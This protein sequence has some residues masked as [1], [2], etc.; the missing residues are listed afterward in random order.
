MEQSGRKRVQMT[1]NTRR[2]EPLS[3]LLSS[4]NNCP[5][6]PRIL[7][8]KEAVP[9]SSPGEGLNTCKSAVSEE[10]GVPL[11]HGGARKVGSP[12]DPGGSEKSLQI[13]SLSD[14]IGHLRQKEGLHAAGVA[15]VPKAAGKED[16][17]DRAALATSPGDRSWG[18]DKP[19][20]RNLG[21]LRWWPT[22]PAF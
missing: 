17:R 19:C 22:S 8:G 5:Q 6:L 2:Q 7:H 12:G 15:A 1:A 3:Y 21:L 20:D 13:G 16:I 11:D 4:A 9:G 14:L 10:R 18:Q